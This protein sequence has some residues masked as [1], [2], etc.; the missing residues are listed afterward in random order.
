MASPE[1]S[2]FRLR[3][4]YLDVIAE[5]GSAFVG[6]WARLQWGPV[7]LHF[8]SLLRAS[9]GSE[10]VQQHTL[11]RCPPPR[12]DGDSCSWSCPPLG[13]AIPLAAGVLAAWGILL[14]PAVAAILMSASTVI[15]AV[16]AQLLRRSMGGQHAW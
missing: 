1:R 4:W 11:Q 14:A 12:L 15:V 2:A 6:Y 10:P 9:D 13:V 8:A 7:R 5:D 16:N 3:K